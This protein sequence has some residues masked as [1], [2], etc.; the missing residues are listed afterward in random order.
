MS[1]VCCQ[2]Y[3]QTTQKFSPKPG[4]GEMVVWFQIALLLAVA[5]AVPITT[6]TRT[7]HTITDPY[8]QHHSEQ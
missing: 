7:K 4:Y 3:F 2:C 8:A 5:L 6:V 1:V